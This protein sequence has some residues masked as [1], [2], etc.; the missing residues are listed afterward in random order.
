MYEK[1]DSKKV[2]ALRI[3]RPITWE[4]LTAEQRRIALANA[5]SLDPKVLDKAIRLAKKFR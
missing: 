5:L 2:E 3:R 4:K 1:G